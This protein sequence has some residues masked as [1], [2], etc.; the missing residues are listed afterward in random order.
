MEWWSVWHL[1]YDKQSVIQYANILYKQ[2]Y[3]KIMFITYKLTPMSQRI[4]TN[5]RLSFTSSHTSRLFTFPLS[6]F[7]F[8]MK[9]Q[10]SWVL[11]SQISRTA[12]LQLQVDFYSMQRMYNAVLRFLLSRALMQRNNLLRNTWQSWIRSM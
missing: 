5:Y 9:R 3:R 12:A 8:W 4:Y 1:H 7:H 11:T 2:P 6:C 10:F